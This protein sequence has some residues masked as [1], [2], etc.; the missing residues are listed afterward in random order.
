MKKKE[1]LDNELKELSP[2]L[3]DLKRKEDGFKLP[4]DYFETFEHSVFQKMGAH[5]VPKNTG[6]QGIRGGGFKFYFLKPQIL[7][8]VAASLTLIFS[9]WWFL[10]PSQV[11][12]PPN[13]VAMELTGE[14]VESYVLENIQEFETEQL[15]TLSEDSALPSETPL[16]ST[17]P[18]STKM[19]PDSEDISPEDVEDLLKDMS[20]EEL[21]QLL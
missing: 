21:E 11:V 9:A 1:S 10:N 2:F 3:H 20:D 5:G 6:M 7:M 8:A 12:A 18:K 4:A 19:K 14:E 13:P 17:T 15:V 16:Q